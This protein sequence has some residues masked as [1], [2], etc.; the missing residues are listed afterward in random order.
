MW[1]SLSSAITA[2]AS[3]RLRG[4]PASGRPGPIGTGVKSA[5]ARRKPADRHCLCR[6]AASPGPA[7]ASPSSLHASRAVR[8]KPPASRFRSSSASPP[9]LRPGSAAREIPLGKI[10]RRTGK[11]RPHKVADRR[12]LGAVAGFLPVIGCVW[13]GRT[14]KLPP[15]S[16]PLYSS[17]GPPTALPTTPTQTRGCS[18]RRQTP[19]P[20]SRGL[21]SPADRDDQSARASPHRDRHH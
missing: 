1:V 6:Q 8:G 17:S 16:T 7:L 3:G 13:I 5:E 9:P 15:P 11:P 21:S 20:R 12:R 2:N 14:Q 4:V 19:G 10:E 18:S